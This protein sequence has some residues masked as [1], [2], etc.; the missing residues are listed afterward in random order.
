MW[1]LQVSL[2]PLGLQPNSAARTLAVPLQKA[3][4]SKASL[5]LSVQWLK[6][7]KPPL[8]PHQQQAR[9][10]LAQRAP[11]LQQPDPR[12]EPAAGMEAWQGQQSPRPAAAADPGSPDTDLSAFAP[13]GKN[14][15]WQD[16]VSDAAVVSVIGVHCNLNGIC[17][18]GHAA[19][20]VSADAEQDLIYNLQFLQKQ[21]KG[22]A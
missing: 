11:V 8:R 2:C 9:K 17:Q 4:T 21:V 7:T 14:V 22:A 6:S 16:K 15:S 3:Q 13:S 10:A 19:C 12:Q 1:H 20:V 5:Q 18:S